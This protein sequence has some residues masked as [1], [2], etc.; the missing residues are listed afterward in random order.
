MSPMPAAKKVL[1][2]RSSHMNISEAIVG[3]ALSKLLLNCMF[4]MDLDAA[5]CEL[6]SQNQNSPHALLRDETR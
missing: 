2:Y 5:Q 6:F 4:A 3:I 1:S